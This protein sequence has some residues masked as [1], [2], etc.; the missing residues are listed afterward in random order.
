MAE[1][2][3]RAQSKPG[4]GALGWLVRRLAGSDAGRIEIETPSGARW[5]HQGEHPGP[6]ARIIVRRWSA[7]RR[8]ITG[9]DIGFAE[10]YRVGDW[11]TPDLVAFF[12]W[13][14]ANEAALTMAWRGSST[15]RLIDRLRHA[16]RA[17]T[18]SG[19]RR[20]IS[21]HYDLGNNFYAAWLDSGINYSSALYLR[22]DETLEAAQLNKLDRV[23]GHL[24]L[25]PDAKVLE[26]GCG[27]GAL[28]ERLIESSSSHVTGV[29]L[30]VEQLRYARSR[31]ALAGHAAKSDL[32]LVDYRD[33]TGTFDGI[34]SI[35]ML[36]AV[37]ESYWPVYFAKLRSLLRPGARAV[38]QVITINEDRFESY[39]S[40]PDFIQRYIFPGGML[41][42]KTLMRE[43]VAQSGLRLVEHEFFAVSYA[44][45][46]SVWRSRFQAAWPQ[47][48]AMGYDENFRRVWDYY[49]AYCEAGFRL[50]ALDVGIYVL[51]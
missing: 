7:L 45:T 4:L 34:V 44:T 1:T 24:Q 31:L 14:T 51:E 16:G 38:V 5:V 8:L 26:I 20:N 27:W 28:A 22:G 17:N 35:E 48:Q 46:L 43:H 12:T 30:S 11:W 25:P 29:T 6:D 36:E 33:L 47:L 10:G 19:S 40:R 32:Q 23:I 41:P 18:R 9:G 37:G 49:L 3:E 42:T 39:R 13:V 50:D 21:A 15:A 2:V